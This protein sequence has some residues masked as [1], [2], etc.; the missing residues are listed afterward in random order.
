MESG[1]RTTDVELLLLNENIQKTIP[2]T[3]NSDTLIDDGLRIG[4]W[5]IF[6]FADE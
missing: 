5:R 2:P 4:I 1:R 6:D 3:V